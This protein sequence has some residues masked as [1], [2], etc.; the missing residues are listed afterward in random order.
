MDRK[1]EDRTPTIE[2]HGNGQTTTTTYVLAEPSRLKYL[3]GIGSNEN[4]GSLF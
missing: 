3:E 2:D 1:R 4:T